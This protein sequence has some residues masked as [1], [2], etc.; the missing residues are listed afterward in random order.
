MCAVD[1]EGLQTGHFFDTACL[2]AFV[3]ETTCPCGADVVYL[4]HGRSLMLVS[5]HVFRRPEKTN[6]PVENG[7][8][9]LSMVP[10]VR[11]V[12]S[13]LEIWKAKLLCFGEA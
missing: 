9:L 11:L 4:S 6:F 2:L 12:C 13:V 5:A 1:G 3:R 8:C 7:S 10:V